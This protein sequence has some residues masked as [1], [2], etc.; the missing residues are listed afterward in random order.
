MT[1]EDRLL[2]ADAINYVVANL[3]GVAEYSKSLQG[4]WNDAILAIIDQVTLRIASN[5]PKFNKAEFFKSCVAGKY[6]KVN[7]DLKRRGY[8]K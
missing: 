3:K 7:A 5:S 2:V 1:K 4:A 8:T 6:T